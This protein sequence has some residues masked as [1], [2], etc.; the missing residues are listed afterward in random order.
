[1]IINADGSINADELI[2]RLLEV[3][4]TMDKALSDMNDIAMSLGVDIEPVIGK[5]K[6]DTGKILSTQDI[7]NNCS[8]DGNT[9]KLPQV[10]LNKKVYAEVKKTLENAGAV[11]EGGKKQE[12]V[13]PFN[14]ERIMNELKSGKIINLQQ[15]FQFFETPADVSDYIVSFANIEENDSILEP[16]A[17]RG[18]IIKAIH[19][20]NPNALIECYEL[21]P[22]NRGFLLE[23]DKVHLIGFDFINEAKPHKYNKIIANPP[24]SNNQDMLHVQEMY[25]CLKDGG[26]L[27]AITGAGYTFRQDKKATEFREWLNSVGAEQYSL[28]KG[29]FKESGTTIETKVIVI[30]KT[31]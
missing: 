14:P 25:N 30:K 2:K 29:K 11:W 15:D 18:S 10:Q 8:I 22:E 3:N 21:M 5:I 31:Q 27:I 16:S 19:K 7:I 12:F 17:G 4:N 20:V 23:M 1:M 28:P 26:K 6:I 13:F 9:V 24:F